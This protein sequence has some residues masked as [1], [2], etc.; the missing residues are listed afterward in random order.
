MSVHIPAELFPLFRSAG[1]VQF[2]PPK[3]NIFTQGDPASNL[4]LVAS[5]RVRAFALTAEGQEITIEVLEGG[6]IFGDSSFLP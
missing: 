6:R 3:T 1:Q 2:L 5:G 4:Y